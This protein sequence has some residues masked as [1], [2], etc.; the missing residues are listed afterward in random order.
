MHN[1]DRALR[2]GL[3]SLKRKTIALYIQMNVILP[4]RQFR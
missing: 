3:M 2:R 4:L 1:G